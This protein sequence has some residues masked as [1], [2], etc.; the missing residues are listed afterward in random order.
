MPLKRCQHCGVEY[1]GRWRNTPAVCPACVLA[2]VV[3]PA[4]WRVERVEDDPAQLALFPAAEMTRRGVF[5]SV[6]EL[7][8]EHFAT[9]LPLDLERVNIPEWPGRASNA[10]RARYPFH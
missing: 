8:R 7:V 6:A 5:A 1:F 2:V 4:C 9:R 3:C 10:E